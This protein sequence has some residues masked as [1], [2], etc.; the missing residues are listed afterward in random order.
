[1]TYLT[2]RHADF[3][4]LIDLVHLGLTAILAFIEEKL[5]NVAYFHFSG[6]QIYYN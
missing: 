6:V 5:K 3:H 4:Y 1:M 2:V